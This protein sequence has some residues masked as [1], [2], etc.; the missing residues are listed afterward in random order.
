MPDQNAAGSTA[1]VCLHCT[2]KV[3]SLP[4]PLLIHRLPIPLPPRRK[5][6]RLSLVY[7]FRA[8]SIRLTSRASP[9]SLHALTDLYESIC[10][11]RAHNALHQCGPSRGNTC[12]EHGAGRRQAK[13]M[14]CERSQNTNQSCRPSRERSLRADLAAKTQENLGGT[15]RTTVSAQNDHEQTSGTENT[16]RRASAKDEVQHMIGN[17]DTTRQ[18]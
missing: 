7:R 18:T 6:K 17:I 9:R 4:T 12:S 13:S 16:D 5:P 3:I 10:P 8:I 11:H 14:T 2:Q 1:I 15:E